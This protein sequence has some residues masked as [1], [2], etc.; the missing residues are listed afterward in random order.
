MNQHAER[1]GQKL[2][3]LKVIVQKHRQTCT[4][5]SGRLLCLVHFPTPHRHSKDQVATRQVEQEKTKST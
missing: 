5:T 3:S 4:R 1:L 2:F